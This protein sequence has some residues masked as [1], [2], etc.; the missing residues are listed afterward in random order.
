MLRYVIFDMDGVIIDSEPVHARAAANALNH[1]GAK[2]D[3]P[4]C[5]QFIGSTT[6]FMIETAISDFHMN[7]TPDQLLTAVEAEKVRLTLE[8]GY[9]A[10]PHVCT[11]IHNLYEHK[12]KLA[13]ASSSNPDEI[14][15]AVTALSVKSC[16]DKLVSGCTVANP[17]PA[18]DVFLKALDELGASKE[19]CLIIEDSTN[20]L[21][22][23]KA[24]GIPAI[25]FANPNSGT[26]DLSAS[27]L[28]VEGFEEVDYKF[29]SDAYCRFYR[30]P[31]TILQT[32][33]LTVREMMPEDIPA[34]FQIYQ[35]EEILKYNDPLSISL[36]TEMEKQ[37]AYIEQIY[38]FYGYGI[39]GVFETSSEKL[40]GRCGIEYK[41]LEET[42][43]FEL[44]Y[45]F[46]RSFWGRGYAMECVTAVLAYAEEQLD[47]QNVTAV[48][49]KHNI[50]SI[51][52]AEKLGFR[53]K[54]G[55]RRKNRE[56][57]LYTLSISDRNQFKKKQETAA[58]IKKIY[59]E[60]PDTSV[61]G[62]RY[63]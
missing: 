4:Y 39:W 28:V 60:Q 57:L 23:A 27:F 54:G 7:I 45:L 11:L 25:G 1:F 9:H 26:Q 22:A 3:I 17:K 59:Q 13:V 19:E 8:E 51:R 37:K 40:I 14:E 31:I 48:I 43:E 16:F 53:L 62:K 32:Q 30:L 34:L 33:R 5:Y 21:L 55:I 46:D 52:F 47:I 41:C 56:C 12:V 63:S 61:Y 35:E 36:E 15:K 49:D 20:G 42:G 24:A 38:H 50:R 44:S 29:L 58:R 18:P 10:I 2:A 6:R